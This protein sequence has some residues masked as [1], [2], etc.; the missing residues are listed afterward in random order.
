MGIL[1]MNP[2]VEHGLE[3]RATMGTRMHAR[4][5]PLRNY[6]IGIIVKV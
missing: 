6:V 4:Q 2:L 3:G 1:P 5:D